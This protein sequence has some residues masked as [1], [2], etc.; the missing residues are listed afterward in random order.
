[1][2]S[3]LQVLR[4]DDGKLSIKCEDGSVLGPFECVL[5][6]TGRK[7]DVESMGLQRAGVALDK[8]GHVVVDDFQR[9]SV[10]N[11][12][13]I[14]DVCGKV[15]LTPMAIAAGRRLADRSAHR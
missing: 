8:Q 1:M 14:G 9:T 2:C 10:S 11:V 3:T 6:A 12:H 5:M 13:A 7:A 4:S 15:Q